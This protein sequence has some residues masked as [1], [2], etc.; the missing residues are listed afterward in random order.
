MNAMVDDSFELDGILDNLIE[1]FYP[2][3]PFSNIPAHVNFEALMAEYLAMSQAFPYLQAGSQK[4]LFWHYMENNEDVPQNIE[5]TS[6]VGNFLCWDETGGLYPTVSSGMKALPRIL[7]THRFHYNILK[8]DLNTLFSKDVKP[9]YSA[10]TKKYLIELFDLLAEP[11]PIKRT[12]CMVSFESHANRMITSLW[13]SLAAQ[14]KIEKNK[15]T[16]FALHV[17]DNPAE[18]FHVQMTRNLIQKIVNKNQFDEFKEA[19][20]SSYYLNHAWCET[21]VNMNKK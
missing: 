16:Y 9:N 6:V 20:L 14:F 18:I 21:I 13:K 7:E 15:L 17:G 8:K 12:A 19:F 10:Q 3:H 11:C 5:L 1:D 2:E 4:D